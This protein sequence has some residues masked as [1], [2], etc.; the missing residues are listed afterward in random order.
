[1]KATG[2]VR[3]VD[4]LGR[5]VLPI[6]LRRTLNIQ[7]KDGLEIFTEG[8][9]IIL[10][11]YEPGCIFCNEVEEVREFR[12]KMVCEKC[13]EDLANVNVQVW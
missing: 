6:E 13:R 12:G 1:M 9:Q 4:Q 11:K 10:R 3:Q 7:E 5:V 8:D 2:V